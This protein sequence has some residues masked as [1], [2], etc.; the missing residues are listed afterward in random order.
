[1]QV[2]R[3]EELPPQRVAR[4]NIET[5][6]TR[7]KSGAHRDTADSSAISKTPR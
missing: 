2:P 5:E 7:M 6:E 4:E 1:M 3:L